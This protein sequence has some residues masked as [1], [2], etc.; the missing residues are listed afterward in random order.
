MM[1]VVS[2]L[3]AEAPGSEAAH[4]YSAALLF[5]EG[6]TELALKEAQAVIAGNPGH[7][8]A[9]NLAGACLAS[10][11][12]RDQA[13]AAFRASLAADPQGSGDLLKPGNARATGRQPRA[14]RQYFAEAL[15]VDPTSETARAGLA[16]LSRSQS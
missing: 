2:R 5:I 3:R 14:G 1:P 4:Y 11:G 15:T 10:L 7:A 8:K 12:Q 13:R 16:D 9:Q 6:R